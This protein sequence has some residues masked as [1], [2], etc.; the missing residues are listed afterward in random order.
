[1]QNRFEL[2]GKIRAIKAIKPEKP[3]FGRAIHNIVS[4]RAIQ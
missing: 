2:R 1:M 3:V 4:Y